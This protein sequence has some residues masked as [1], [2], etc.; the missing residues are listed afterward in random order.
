VKP[1]PFEY[2][3]ARSLAE[4]IA[5]LADDPDARVLAGGQSLVPM[6]NMRLVRPSAVVDIARVPGLEAVDVEAAGTLVLGALVR[7]ADL[8][9]SPVVRRVAPL[10]AVAASHIGHRAIRNRGTLGG[11]LAHADP[12]A[13]L[14]AAAVALGARIRLAGRDG[15]REVAAA[16]FFRGLFTTALGAGEVVTGIRIPPGDGGGWGFAEIARRPGDFALAGVAGILATAPDGSCRSARLVAFGVGT[17]PVRLATAETALIGLHV[18]VAR[19]RDAGIAA[20]AAVDPPD[21][22]HASAEYR[23]HLVSV[24]TERV[25]TQ[26]LGLGDVQG[27]AARPGETRSA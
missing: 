4:A 5:R 3:R 9:A 11:S 8:A 25:V 12:A 18:E 15:T 22:V 16:E 23:R 26:A 13:E 19:A 17:G 6:M 27:R 20:A 2:V 1:A 7:H 10:L 24:L 21:D 14:P